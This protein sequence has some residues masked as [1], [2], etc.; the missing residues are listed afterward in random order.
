MAPKVRWGH[1]DQM[2]LM[3]QTVHLGHSARWGRK[4]RSVQK[5]QTGQ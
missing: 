5:A 3:D 4:V 2:G 1:L